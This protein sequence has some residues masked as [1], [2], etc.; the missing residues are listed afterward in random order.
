MGTIP[1]LEYQA[2]VK[3]IKRKILDAQYMALEAVNRKLINLNRDIGKTIVEK[4]EEFGW[5]KSI[6]ETLPKQLQNEF[7]GT[8]GYSVQ[9]FGICGSFTCCRRVP[10][11]HALWVYFFSTIVN[12]NPME[13]VH[14]VCYP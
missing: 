6:V 4:Q 5:G 2:F 9:N 7:P 14:I 8:K 13:F 11:P 3:E 1:G 12:Y 10:A